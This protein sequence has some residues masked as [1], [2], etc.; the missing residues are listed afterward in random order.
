VIPHIPEEV[1]R[2]I[3]DVADKTDSD[4]TLVEVGGTVGDYQNVLFLEAFRT[5][6]IRSEPVVFIHLVY[7]PI[8]RN[9]GEMKTKPAQHSV[10]T[11][12]EIGI[13][14]D[15]LVT[16]SEKD[17]D[18]VRRKKLSLFCNVSPE[19]VISNP[20]V[21]LIYEMPLVFLKQD[22]L[23]KILSKFGIGDGGC[24]LEDWKGLI[25]RI[26]SLSKEVRVGVVGKYFD[27]GDFTLEDSYISVI[28]AVKHA[29][30]NLGLRPRIEWIDSKGFEKDPTRYLTWVSVTGCTSLLWSSQGAH[31]GWR[32]QTPQRLTATQNTL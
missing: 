20:D 25:S 5:M 11:L 21:D 22:F 19:N 17:L 31:A 12:N 29:S 24:D 14:P 7:L 8:P 30:W 3:K 1:E 4:F 15:F 27:I 18:D 9:L 10:R 32:R 2:R 23:N 16:R 28:E 6:R 13:Q 26:K